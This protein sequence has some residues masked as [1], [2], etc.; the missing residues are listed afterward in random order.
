MTGFLLLLIG[1]LSVAGI[2]Y[3]YSRMEEGDDFKKAITILMAVVVVLLTVFMVFDAQ[4]QDMALASSEYNK[5]T[6][7]ILLGWTGS[8]SPYI[9]ESW[10]GTEPEQDFDFD[11]VKN[12][13]DSDADNDGVPDYLEYGTRFQPYQPDIGILDM[14][15][16]WVN[17]DQLSVRVYSVQDMTGLDASITVMLDSIVYAEG[18]F[19]QVN[20]FTIGVDSSRQ[21]TLEFKVDG[22]E[23]NYANKINNF[24]SYTIPPGVTGE[25]GRWYS[26]LENTIQGIIR[27][28]PLYEVTNG[29][30]VF[31]QAIRGFLANFPL[32]LWVATIFLIV[33]AWWYNKRRIR[34]G[35]PPLLSWGRK[36]EDRYEKGTT[37][38]QLY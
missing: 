12:L 16:K 35:K 25:I 21:Y 24:I 7:A 20:D 19:T 30:G 37:R 4:T 1:V 34:K 22:I 32:F 9:V 5:A 26:D 11:G 15:V 2:W 10:G 13:W 28:S 14:E 8:Y 27:N 29:F 18:D 23:S 36:K 3:I 33:F 38:I 17:E 6:L 31:E